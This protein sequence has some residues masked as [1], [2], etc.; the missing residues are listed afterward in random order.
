MRFKVTNRRCNHSSQVWHGFLICTVGH[1]DLANE[2]RVAQALNHLQLT[3]IVIAHRPQTIANTER[4]LAV[5]NGQIEELAHQE[6]H[7]RTAVEL[8]KN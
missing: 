4:V 6:V 3:R 2:Q 5:R 7:Q 8:V 1:L